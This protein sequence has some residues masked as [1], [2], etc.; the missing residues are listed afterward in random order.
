MHRALECASEIT[1]MD[2]DDNILFSRSL[3]PVLTRRTPP[4]NTSCMKTM[5]NGC[6]KGKNID[7][8]FRVVPANGCG[9][10]E[11]VR[12]RFLL[13]TAN[14]PTE[15]SLLLIKDRGLCWNN[16]LDIVHGPIFGVLGTL[17]RPGREVWQP[18]RGSLPTPSSVQY[19]ISAL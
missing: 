14:T 4:K 10:R 13:M 16:P 1:S 2:T 12:R 5:A 11:I 15:L 7:Q 3:L 6:A 19:T 17:L 18:G 9:T 8:R